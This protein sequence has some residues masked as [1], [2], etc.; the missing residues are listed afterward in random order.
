MRDPVYTRLVSSVLLARNGCPIESA[1]D[2]VQLQAGEIA[3][4]I[5]GGK[6]GNKNRL[7]SPW[8]SKD[9]KAKKKEDDAPEVDD[10]DVI[11]WCDTMV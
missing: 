11:R 6:T 10:V 1:N 7:L 2:S 3:V 5:D 9:N 8:Q 4:L